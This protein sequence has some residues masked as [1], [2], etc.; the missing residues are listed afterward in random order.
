M[1][2]RLSNAALPLARVFSK[3]LSISM[4]EGLPLQGAKAFHLLPSPQSARRLTGSIYQDEGPSLERRSCA[5]Y[6]HQSTLT[7]LQPMSVLAS[8][9][10]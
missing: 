8:R 6:S 7:L 3:R 5:R 2:H 1:T 9:R 10:R 4:L